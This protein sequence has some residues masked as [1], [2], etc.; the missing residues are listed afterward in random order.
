MFDWN[1]HG[2]SS[3][4]HGQGCLNF[5][6]RSYPLERH[7]SNYNPSGYG[8]IVEHIWVFSLG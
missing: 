4:N 3:L 8:Q 2:E 6:E 5:T 1:G 7:E